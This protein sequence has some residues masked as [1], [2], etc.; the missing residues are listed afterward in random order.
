V[1]AARK[2][3]VGLSFHTKEALGG[4]GF[5]RGL[6]VAAVSCTAVVGGY[7]VEAGAL[8]PWSF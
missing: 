7:H 5:G 8:I 6:Y 1:K 4:L 2:P 3:H